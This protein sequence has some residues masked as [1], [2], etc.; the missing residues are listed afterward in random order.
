MTEPATGG[1]RWQSGS[2]G[3]AGSRGS[4]GHSQNVG[5]VNVQTRPELSEKL[6]QSEQAREAH[7]QDNQ[8]HHE[9]NRKVNNHMSRMEE[10]WAQMKKHMSANCSQHDSPGSAGTRDHDGY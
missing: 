2:A 5:A 10:E 6:A 1:Q 4:P 8:V 7:R 3:R 9:E